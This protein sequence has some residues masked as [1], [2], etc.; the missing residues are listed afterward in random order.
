MLTVSVPGVPGVADA[1][2]HVGPA[3]TE[4]ETM[5]ARVT[6]PVKPLAD[7]AVT[8]EVA[9][10][11]DGSDAGESAVA[12]SEKS[13]AASLRIFDHESVGASFVTGLKSARCGGETRGRAG[14]SGHIDVSAGAIDG[15]AAQIAVDIFVSAAAEEGRKSQG[16]A[17]RIKLG[18]K[19]IGVSQ[20]VGGLGSVAGREVGGSGLPCNIAVSAGIDCNARAFVG[21]V[22]SEEG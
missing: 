9:V 17:S 14:V 1:V 19:G 2:P 13:L 6:L 22:A 7:A 11:P 3:V 21:P 12:V 10:P 4:G 20:S 15:N 5:Q 16:R 18:H 8:V